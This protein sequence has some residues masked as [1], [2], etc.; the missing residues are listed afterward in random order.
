MLAGTLL[1][2]PGIPHDAN[3]DPGAWIDRAAM[4][5]ATHSPRK[6]S[7]NWHDLLPIGGVE[8]GRAFPA[9]RNCAL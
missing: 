7:S 1:R 2:P 3:A 8:N 5:P 6:T 4:S 9:V